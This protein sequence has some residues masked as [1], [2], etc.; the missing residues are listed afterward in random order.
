MRREV[1]RVAW[2]VAG[3]VVALGIVL[4]CGIAF[5]Q[6]PDAPGRAPMPGRFPGRGVIVGTVAQKD[7][8]NNA[9]LVRS[10]DGQQQWVQ[11]L[12][13]T[14]I[15]KQVDAKLE[16]IKEKEPVA[17]TGT[18]AALTAASCVLGAPL[19]QAGAGAPGGGPFPGG[20][21]APG[22]P[23]GAAN[24]PGLAAALQARD[25]SRVAGT[26][27]SVD[28]EKRQFVL[29]TPE[30]TKVV[31]T[32]PENARVGRMLQVGVN[33][34]ALGEQF[35]AA[36]EPQQ[37]GEATIIRARM[38]AAGDVSALGGM[39]GMF[40]R[41]QGGGRERPGGVGGRERP[42]G[43]RGGGDRPQRDQPPADQ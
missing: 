42:G 39:F 14:R 13:E 35:A 10:N 20:A 9:V 18:P 1:E 19:A 16:E 7:I 23:A 6:Q 41:F 28:L 3:A 17:V 11:L 40:G 12:P 24:R 30:N 27:E 4:A 29:V 25:T 43:R 37:I 22:G 31:V 38:A 26:V 21:G 32:V 34:V 15:Q 36:G 33:E 5:G 2:M 8:Q